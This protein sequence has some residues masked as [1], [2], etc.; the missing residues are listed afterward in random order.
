MRQLL[1][2]LG[3]LVLF[4]VNASAQDSPS[5]FYSQDE[6]QLVHSWF[7]RLQADLN[8]AAKDTPAILVDKTHSQ[9]SALERNW[10]NGVYDSRQIDEALTTLRGLADDKRLLPADRDKLAADWSQMI[11]LRTEFY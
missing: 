5:R 11:D 1:I 2:G 6:Y 10:D 7:D 9:F 8:Q 3:I 4:V